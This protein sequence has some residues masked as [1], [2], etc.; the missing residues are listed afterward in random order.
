MTCPDCVKGYIL[1][2]EPVGSI[3]A[4]FQGAYFTPGP[5]SDPSKQAVLLFTDAF[6]LPLKNC[7]IIAD[8]LAKRLEC[9]VWIPDYFNGRPLVPVDSMGIPDHA[10]HKLSLW[11]RISFILFY[12]LP[13]LPAI[14]SSRPSVA[15]QRIA[16]FIQLLKEK[17]KYQ[18]LGA[19]GYCFGGTMG[20]RTGR[21]D[22]LDSLV[23]CHPGPSTLDDVKAIKV[24]TAWVC[25]EE[26]EY[27]P[28]SRRN[29]TEA[30]FAARKDKEDFVD[31]E[32]KVYKG[33]RY[34][35]FT[36]SPKV[37]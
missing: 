4:D 21:T 2:G 14:I 28:E 36:E 16:S 37:F 7:K 13:N 9:D 35:P 6:G 19:V 31:Y 8:N 5:G 11:T 23:I 24:P 15:V 20:I 33:W 30:V 18:K 25:A 3:I 17:K 12:I 34:P 29:E 22:L 27:F 26:D 1:P 10:G 32:L